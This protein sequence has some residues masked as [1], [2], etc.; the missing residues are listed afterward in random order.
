MP[1]P[2]SDNDFAIVMKELLDEYS[3][4]KKS[5]KPKPS[6]KTELQRLVPQ[7]DPMAQ[8]LR[9]YNLNQKELKR[10]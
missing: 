4:L 3:T 6:I 10:F 9:K 2:V 1:S 5:V 7:T 8:M